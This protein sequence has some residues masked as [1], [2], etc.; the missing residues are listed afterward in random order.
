MSYLEKMARLHTL[1]I[2]QELRVKENPLPFLKE[3]YDE[4]YAL[5]EELESLYR[6]LSPLPVVISSSDKLEYSSPE[7]EAFDRCEKATE[8]LG[9]CLRKRG[10]I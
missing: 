7:K 8:F 3:A 9:K 1:I 2:S 4:M 6:I 10:I 5:H